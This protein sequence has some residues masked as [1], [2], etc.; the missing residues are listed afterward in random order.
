MRAALRHPFA[1]AGLAIVAAV[2]LASFFG[3]L[4][5]QNDPLA[6]N[7]A[8]RLLPPSW[9]YPLGTDAMGRCLFTRLALGA[10]Y[11]LGVTG[12]VVL[13]IMAVGIPAGFLS[14]YVGGRLD[15]FLMRA[16]D[17]ITALPEF[18][19]AIAIA[20][21]LGSSLTNLMIAVVLVKWTGYARIVRGIVLSEREKEYV[22]AAKIG[23]CG[24]WK[25][26]R[27]HL[28]PHLLPP[29][30]VL[31]ALDVGKVVLAISAL[32]YLGLGA[33]P[34]TPEWGAML[35]DGRPYFQT[36]PELMLIPGA[37]IMIVVLACNL[38]GDG[39]RERLDART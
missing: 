33:Q 23:G 34:P 32:S 10:Q 20:G 14:G 36:A 26:F 19:L 12:L 39:L 31:A 17:A 38:I 30:I 1:A 15:A 7:M 28:L 22:L 6:V 37:A 4:V 35:N 21:F 11:T 16:N 29:V 27:R 25:M 9:E 13:V 5:L 18:L 2:L 3:P 8:E 24:P